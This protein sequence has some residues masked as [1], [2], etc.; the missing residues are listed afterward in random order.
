MWFHASI[1]IVFWLEDLACRS[2]LFLVLGD[3]FLVTSRFL[4]VFLQDKFES[5]V[6]AYS[7][8]FRLLF[9]FFPEGARE[10]C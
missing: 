1:L 10:I 2:L 6:P 9:Y 8:L 7:F 4:E 5:L 3:S